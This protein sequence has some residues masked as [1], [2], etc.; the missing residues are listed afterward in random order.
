VRH[1][2]IFEEFGKSVTYDEIKDILS[3]ITD[4]DLYK[5]I[6]KDTFARFYLGAVAEK[7]YKE[8]DIIERHFGIEIKAINH[9]GLNFSE[10]LPTLKQ[11]VSYLEGC[12]FRM[13]SEHSIGVSAS[14]GVAY[15]KWMRSEDILCAAGGMKYGTE[16]EV[17]SINIMF[18]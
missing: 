11:L 16:R 5:Y 18:E 9:K 3:E 10:I 12:G 4:S 13:M 8:G 15:M 2:K 17:M 7:E 6:I 1:L 14:F